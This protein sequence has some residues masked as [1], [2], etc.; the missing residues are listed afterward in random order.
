MSR[1][2]TETK[3]QKD[4]TK[5]DKKRKLEEAAA[6]KKTPSKSPTLKATEAFIDEQKT[7]EEARAVAAKHL[8]ESEAEEGSASA[9]GAEESAPARV[10]A[11]DADSDEVCMCHI[12]RWADQLYEYDR[13]A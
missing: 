13:K 9:S 10:A 4:S 11:T 8:V 6:K 12:C 3:S 5:E 2:A 7:R 1:K